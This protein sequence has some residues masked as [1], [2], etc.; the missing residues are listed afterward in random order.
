MKWERIESLITLLISAFIIIMVWICTN[1]N[2]DVMYLKIIAT[3]GFLP[4]IFASINKL[5]NQ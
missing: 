2:S 4:Y 3:M 1:S 5:I